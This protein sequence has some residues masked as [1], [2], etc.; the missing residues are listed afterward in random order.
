MTVA[1][2]LTTIIPYTSGSVS[3]V[4]VCV[5]VDGAGNRK[6]KSPVYECSFVRASKDNMHAYING[7]HIKKWYAFYSCDFT[8]NNLDSWDRHVRNEHKDTQ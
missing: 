4:P 3:F 1:V 8:A 6:W 7:F 5:Q 2:T